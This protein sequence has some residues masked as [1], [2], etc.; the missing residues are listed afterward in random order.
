MIRY[1]PRA[2][3]PR[4]CDPEWH[5]FA[6]PRTMDVI[7]PD[8]TAP[9]DTGLL[10]QHGVPLYRVPERVRCGFHVDAGEDG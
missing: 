5:E 7:V 10:D 2:R 4:A 6:Q 1:V 9:E 3:R 8:E